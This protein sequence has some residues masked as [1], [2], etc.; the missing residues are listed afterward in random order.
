[1]YQPK[2]IFPLTL[3]ETICS[4]TKVNI[5]GL[6]EKTLNHLNEIISCNVI[7]NEIKGKINNESNETN[8]G[9]NVNAFKIEDILNNIVTI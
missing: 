8:R 6:E 4:H 9:H 5:T 3:E 7:N 2:D 1:M